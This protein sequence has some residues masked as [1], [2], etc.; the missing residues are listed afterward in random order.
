MRKDTITLNLGEEES[1]RIEAYL[2]STDGLAIHRQVVYLPG[3]EEHKF[4]SRWQVTHIESGK[5]LLRPS[6][7]P[8]TMTEAVVIAKTLNHFD[9]TQACE[10]LITRDGV[11]EALSSALGGATIPPPDTSVSRRYLVRRNQEGAGYVVWDDDTEKVVETFVH[12]GL[13]SEKAKALN[14]TMST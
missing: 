10:T 6:E 4:S 11:R 8:E 7:C 1:M 5:G 13:A 9:W 14:D 12:R 2:S 3:K